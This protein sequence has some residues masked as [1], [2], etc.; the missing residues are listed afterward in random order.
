MIKIG[1]LNISQVLIIISCIAIK[2]DS[3]TKIPTI[4]EE[5]SVENNLKISSIF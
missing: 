3:K 2:A 1:K 5:I 4:T